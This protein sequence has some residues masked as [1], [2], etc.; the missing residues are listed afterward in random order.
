MTVTGIK[1]DQVIC[2]WTDYDGHI[3][4]ESFPIDA[5]QVQ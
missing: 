2:D 3:G 4:S 1:G 5:L